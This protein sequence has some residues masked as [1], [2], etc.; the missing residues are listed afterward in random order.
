MKRR[1]FLNGLGVSTAAMLSPGFK[2]NAQSLGE[3][4]AGNV[5]PRG[6]AE[7]TILVFLQ[8]AP[9]HVDTFDLKLGSWTPSDFEPTEYGNFLLSQRLFGNLGQHYDKFSLL[10]CIEGN[11]AVHQRAQYVIQTGHTFNPVFS[12]EQPHLGSIVAYELNAKRKDTDILPGFVA[13]NGTSSVHGPGM[14]A[15]TYAALKFE[16]NSGLAG[17][18]HP[19]GEDIFN[20]RYKALQSFD[21]LD[22]TGS[23]NGNQVNDFNHFYELG[24]GM[25]YEPDVENSLNVTEDEL[26]KYGDNEVGKACAMAVKLL[27]TNRGTKMVQITQGN[28]DHHY[29]IYSPNGNSNI[30]AQCGQLDPALAAMLEDLAAKPGVRGGSLLDETL[31]LVVGEFGRTPANLTNNGGRDHYPYCWS[32]LVAGSGIQGNQVFGGTD[33]QGY[34]IQDHFWSQN[35]TISPFDLQATVLSSMGIDW[36]KEIQ[37]TPSGRVYEYTPKVNGEPGYYKDIV[38]MFS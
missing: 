20:Q 8:G 13:I 23:Q 33:D 26:T 1:F 5:T 35:R 18:N 22:R 3:T 29:D 31:V 21:E 37:E 9:S 27:A 36:T 15:S 11:E 2:L 17:L 10:R 12:K 32:A 30:Y 25:M 24:E 38:E 14:L 16:A 7:N 4:G 6:S 28:W 19:G 34:F